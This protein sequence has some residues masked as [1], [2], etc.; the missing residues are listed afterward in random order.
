MTH[1]SL[2]SV[3]TKSVF[4]ALA[5]LFALPQASATAPMTPEQAGGIYYAYPVTADSLPPVPAGY[6]PVAI[7]HYGRHGSRWAINE[8][9][10]TNSLRTLTTASETGNLTPEGEAMLEMVRMATENARGHAGELSQ[11]GVRQ[12]RDIAARMA[13]RFPS[14]FQGDARIDARSSEVPRCIISMTSFLN[15]LLRVNP[16]LR[17]HLASS[18]GGMDTMALHIPK[19][20]R[21]LAKDHSKD[22]DRMEFMRRRDS[23]TM[24]LA[25]ASR[26]FNDPQNVENLPE[27]MR[28]IYNIAIA[29]QDMDGI[30]VDM[31]GKF[32]DEDLFNQWKVSNYWHYMEHANT[33]RTWGEGPRSAT[34]LLDDFIRR[35]DSSLAGNGAPVTLRF[36][37]DTV[38]MRLLA[39]MGAS[40]CY[41]Q[42]P[43]VDRA[44]RDWVNFKIS[45]MGAN[46][47]MAFFR[48]PADDVIVALR[49]NEQPLKIDGVTEAYPGYYRWS[50]LRQHL[51]SAIH[52]VAELVERVSPGDSNRFLF[53]QTNGKDDYFDITSDNGR[54]RIE[55]NNPVSIAAGLNWY[56]KYYAGIHLS[57]NNMHTDL[58][59]RLPLPASH[60]RHSTDLLQRYY[61]NYCTH[62]YSMPF[63]DTERWQQEVD[64]MALH[65]INMPL[66]IAGTDEVWRNTL[67]RLGYSQKEADEFVAGPAFQAWWLMNNLEGWGGP[68]SP[69]WYADRVRLQHDI[70]YAMRRYGMEP[71]LPGYSGMVP[72]DAAERLGVKATGTGLWNGFTRPAFLSV[73]DPM[74]PKI[75]RIYYEELEKVN[76]KARYYS[77]DPF[78]ESENIGDVD[79]AEAAGIITKAMKQ[80]NPEAVW[81]VQGW[82]ENPRA[83]LLAGVPKGDIVVLDL[84][85][86]IKPNWGDPDSP[87]LTKRADGYAPHDW[88]WCMLL[89][90]GGNVGLHGRMDNV[91]DG[92]YK[93]KD[94]KWGKDMTGFGLTPE[95][96][97]NNPVMYELASELIWRPEKFSKAEWLKSYAKARYGHSTKDVDKAW[98][99]LGSTIYNAPWGNMQQGTTESVF[100][101]RPS[102]DVWQVSSWSRMAPYY[103]PADVIKAAKDFAKGAKTLKDNANYR[104]D[105][106]DITRQAIAEKGRIVYGD[107]QKALKSNDMKAFDKASARFLALIDDQD[108]LLSTT[109]DFYVGTWI[110]AARRLDPS[111]R[112]S[113]NMERNARLIV[114]TW[115][116]RVASED[117]G[118]RDYAHRE[119]GGLLRDLYKKRWQEWIKARK[120]TD[121]PDIDFYAIDERWVNDRNVYPAPGPDARPVETALQ[122]L[123]TL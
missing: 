112:D 74:F 78:H 31:L 115:G 35:A 14:L 93:A 119:W 60:E 34:P 27:L 91:I 9:I 110:D 24:N 77:M 10:Y 118:L 70:L 123:K 107:M 85:S 51:L 100:C 122:I 121:K 33:A 40:G 82:N 80:A 2:K 64:W 101:A 120:T 66:L 71:V 89:N 99:L 38:L 114:T 59:D 55:G 23:L 8:S 42:E 116:P 76:G 26:L 45:P 36:G 25:T 30:D 69:E 98:S 75:A 62:S 43:G 54:V 16:N 96:I 108:R 86:E 106:V 113:D 83:E 28:D 7:S 6:T 21:H 102:D 109:P 29:I 72:H 18:P 94:S 73:T 4:T 84:A 63:W 81:V 1:R 95:G 32:D 20:R 68:N 97:E 104:Y 52:P 5:A 87:S 57:W 47:Q 56:L 13:A 49:L 46:F 105:L 111:G 53:V 61:L 44:A 15:Q 39:L 90:F 92:F 117:G 11:I 22:A 103:N 12:H 65:G 3:L 37:H 58:G 41:G 17:I 50:N 67:L 19:N 48:N 79:L 88:M